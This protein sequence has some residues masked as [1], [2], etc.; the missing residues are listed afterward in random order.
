MC[1]DEIA[2][3]KDKFVWKFVIFSEGEEKDSYSKELLMNEKILDSA[4]WGPGNCCD[5]DVNGL[6]SWTNV[7]LAI[8]ND[9]LIDYFFVQALKLGWI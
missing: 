2:K 7:F 4:I 9:L 5:K 8:L 6:V 1:I 3:I